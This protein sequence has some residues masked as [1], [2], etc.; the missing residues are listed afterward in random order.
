MI[1]TKAPA[2]YDA[3]LNK[4]SVFLAGSIE[5]GVAEDWQAKVSSALS[6][7]DVLVLNPRRDNWDASWAQTIDNPPF[8][9]Q[10]EWELAA[11]DAADVILMYFDPA[12]K[13]PI[14]LLEL[15]IHAA[16]NPEKLIV[17][18]PQGFW[19][20]GNVDIVC[21]RYGVRQTETLDGLI[22]QTVQLLQA[23]N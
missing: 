7:M 16:A 8:R 4:P 6:V 18:C 1:E 11:L 9:E 19:R 12:T 21:N 5:M 14:T 3:Y 2:A 22:K 20:K 17:C 23:A 13:S 10:V 15:G